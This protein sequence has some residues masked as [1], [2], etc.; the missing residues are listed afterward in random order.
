MTQTVAGPAPI[1]NIFELI[2]FTPELRKDTLALVDGLSKTYGDF[3]MIEIMGTKQ[4]ITSDPEII[5]EILVKQSSKFIKDKDY[6]DT[7]R[8]M[9]RFF[10]NGL[11]T[12][13]GDFWKRQ[14]KLVAP[15]LHVKRI[16]G[17]AETINEF[18]G[19]T[20][21]NWMHGAKIDFS[22]EMTALT[23]KIVVKTLFSAE[24]EDDV[25]KV[26]N[27]MTMIQEYLGEMQFGFIPTWIPTPLELKA[28]RAKR[29]LDEVVYRVI[30]ERRAG[31]EVQD[32]GDLMSMLL[33]AEDE[34]GNRMTDEQVRDEVLTLFLA[35]HETTANTL[36]WTLMLLA[37]HPEV[38]AKLHE[39][40]D[41]VL[42]GRT[43]TLADLRRL[44]YTNM[45]IQEAQRISPPVWMIG[46]E[47]TEDVT[48]KGHVV[49][50]GSMIGMFIYGTHHNP[51]YWESPEVFDP[52]RFSAEN[53][54]KIAKFAYLPFG[55]GPR[56]CIGNSFAMMEAQ[57][58]LANIAQRYTLR[59]A[60]GE[61][62]EKAASI[63]LYPKHGLPMMVR[64]RETTP[65]LA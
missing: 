65:V 25:E 3:F 22:A 11:V 50:K 24:V 33:L 59:V 8:G 56:I 31:G 29:D 2:K 38:E 44:P 37:E 32:N 54:E 15:A 36:N 57:L 28:R 63:T 14:R 48:L 17:Y 58:I 35:G 20:L 10:G 5:Y 27:A 39:E 53:E 19:D 9:A 30:N 6:R 45:V 40:L 13:N 34:D 60:P 18:T 23:L 55:G 47:V 12:S 46:R 42:Q 4:Y 49:P 26:G 7:K 61:T 52:E 21:A 43:P 16:E 51:K 1:K 62:V 64:E 41:T